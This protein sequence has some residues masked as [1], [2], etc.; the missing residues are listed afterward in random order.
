VEDVQLPNINAEK[1][2]SE[3][4]A[5]GDRVFVNCLRGRLKP[6]DIGLD[7]L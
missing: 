6:L 1:K 5:K 2:P 7:E 4:L 3:E